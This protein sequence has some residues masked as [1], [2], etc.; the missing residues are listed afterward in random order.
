MSPLFCHNTRAY[1]IVTKQL[2]LDT[3]LISHRTQRYTVVQSRGIITDISINHI[4]PLTGP[5]PRLNSIVLFTSWWNTY[6]DLPWTGGGGGGGGGGDVI[7]V[8]VRVLLAV[9]PH[10]PEVSSS[11]QSASTAARPQEGDSQRYHPDNTWYTPPPSS[12]L[13]PPIHLVLT[14]D[15]SHYC[16]TAC[17]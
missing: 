9:A 13:L 2:K 14:P 1:S 5:S 8:E 16:S 17:F 15:P 4:Y 12:L 11:Y 3:S 7:R 10:Y 6:L